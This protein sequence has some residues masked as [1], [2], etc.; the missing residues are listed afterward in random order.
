MSCMQ[1]ITCNLSVTVISLGQ[2]ILMR[3]ITNMVLRSF[4]A[5]FHALFPWNRRLNDEEPFLHSGKTMSRD[6][7]MIS[8]TERLDPIDGLPT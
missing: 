5:C 6:D 4:M 2:C 1:C 3:S 7:I 8:L